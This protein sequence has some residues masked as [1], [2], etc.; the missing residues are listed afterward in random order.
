[1]HI[2]ICDDNVADRK[3]LERLLGRESDAR[4]NTSGVFY[5]DSF[6][7]GAL[8]FPK[9]KSYDLFF[10]DLVDDSENGFEFAL[11]LCDEG[12]TAPIVLCSSKNDYAKKAVELGNYPPN[13]LFIN[14]PIIKAE[15]SEILDK[16]I[17][18]EADQAPTIEIRH[19]TET[20]YV[21]EDDIVYVKTEKN[22]LYV[23]LKDGTSIP[24]IDTM[25]NFFT[26]L[27]CY[28]HYAHINPSTVINALYIE[29][30]SPFKVTLKSGLSFPVTL[31]GKKAIKEA[32]D[33]IRK[34]NESK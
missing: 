13:I 7:E 15:L 21:F 18:I 30:Y 9:R 33:Y 16:A 23:Y 26:T 24:V 14:K 6:G 34:E 12:V 3:Q 5:T 22:G 17:K 8:L 31:S 27:N 25:T 19:N 32:M 29:K 10:I 2:A 11:D 20:Y 4:M 1:M 28:T